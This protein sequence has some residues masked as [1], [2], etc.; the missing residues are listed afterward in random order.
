MVGPVA[1]QIG[2]DFD[3]VNKAFGKLSDLGLR[4]SMAGRGLRQMFIVTAAT[5]ILKAPGVLPK[6]VSSR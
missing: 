5:I 1:A 2:A 3:Q 4:G 6:V